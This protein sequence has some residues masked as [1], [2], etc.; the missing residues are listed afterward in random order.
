MRV[1][2]IDDQPLLRDLLAEFLELLGHTSDLVAD[3]PEA[4]ARF[5]PL[6]HQAVITDL[7]MPGLTGLEVAASIRARGCTTPIVMLSGH[8]EPDDERRAAQAGLR[9]VRK[10]VSFAKFEATMIEVAEHAGAAR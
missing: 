2:V 6:V 4:L 5:D 9:F 3:G 10:P 1:L 8:A 7:L